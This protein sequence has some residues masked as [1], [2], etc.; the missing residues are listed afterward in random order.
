[1]PLIFHGEIEQAALDRARME[2][3]ARIDRIKA[4]C[5]PGFAYLRG[6]EVL[7]DVDHLHDHLG[8]FGV[9]YGASPAN[10]AALTSVHHGTV[11]PSRSR[12]CRPGLPCCESSTS[13]TFGMASSALNGAFGPP[14]AVRIQPGA[15]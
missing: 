9:F 4:D 14:R 13:T 1:M 11:R 3:Y 12:Y 8:R 5:V 6:Q 15:I 7:F 2:G 10:D